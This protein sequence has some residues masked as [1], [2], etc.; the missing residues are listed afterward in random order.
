[1]STRD[2]IA[3]FGT[4][5]VRW[6]VERGRWQRPVKG[7][8]VTH[9]IGL[10][11]DEQLWCALIAHGPGATAAGLTGAT[12]DGFTGFT[13]TT[14][15]VLI[16]R[17]QRPRQ[18]PQ[19]RVHT[20]TLRDDEVHPARTP[21]RTRIER[22]IIDAASW[23]SNPLQTQGILAASVQQGLVTPEGLQEAM[24]PRLT[25]P[26]RPLIVET[27]RDVAGGSLSEYEVL[28]ARLCRDEG[29]PQPSR[30]VRRRDTTGRMRYLDAEFDEYDLVAEIDGQ[31]H[32]E[33]LAWW[34]DMQRSN[35]I[36]ADGKW[37]LRF[38]GFALRHQGDRVADVLRRFFERSSRTG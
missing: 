26:K 29:F 23:A 9:P 27:L 7:V 34:A 18:L 24:A 13:S 33:A 37:L 12:L 22:S 16:P 4:G 32:M 2:A 5:H 17:G 21:R 14:R 15:D 28:F 30:Q 6:M 3:Q 8:I 31:H 25:L 10:T 36:V 11:H 1:M 35:E 20:A 19:V 38:A